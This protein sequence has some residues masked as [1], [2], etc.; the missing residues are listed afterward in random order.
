MSIYL[1][2][3][4]N[5][6]KSNNGTFNNMIDAIKNCQQGKKTELIPL[7]IFDNVEG[8]FGNYLDQEI[9]VNFFNE[10]I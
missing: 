2:N 4:L 9:R 1:V 3:L 5:L 6:A 10:L 7:I 8:L